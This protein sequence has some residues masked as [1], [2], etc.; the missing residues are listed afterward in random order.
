[1]QKTANCE[2]VMKHVKK[3]RVRNYFASVE[4]QTKYVKR[5]EN[6]EQIIS[7]RETV[8]IFCIF[9]KSHEIII[10]LV[11]R[12][13]ISSICDVRALISLVVAAVAVA[14]VVMAVVVLVAA[15]AAAVIL[16]IRPATLI[17]KLYDQRCY[18]CDLSRLLFGRSV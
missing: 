17:M 3:E 11:T 6:E 7:S 10:D 4:C 14:V 5:Q 16:S 15:A 9:A 8:T 1:M 2:C 18:S 12:P 13:I